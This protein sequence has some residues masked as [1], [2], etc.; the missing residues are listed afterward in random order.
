MRTPRRSSTTWW[1]GVCH[2]GLGEGLSPAQP[3]V[4]ALVLVC[5]SHQNRRTQ[6]EGLKQQELIFSL[7]W[8][9]A[10]QEYDM[11][12]SLG[13]PSLACKRLALSLSPHVVVPLGLS[14]T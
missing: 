1:A 6:T 8:R 7:F 3:L 9:L 14:V 11:G 4:S 5:S 12:V 10:V 13:S 2:G